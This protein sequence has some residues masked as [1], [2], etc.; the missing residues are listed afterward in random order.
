MGMI[1]GAPTVSSMPTMETVVFGV[2]GLPFADAQH[3]AR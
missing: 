2:G 1:F 3:D